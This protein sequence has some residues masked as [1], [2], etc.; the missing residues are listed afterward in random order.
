MSN[1]AD[2]VIEEIESRGQLIAAAH[3]ADKLREFVVKMQA[4]LAILTQVFARARIELERESEK[5]P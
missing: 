3:K 2:K 1:E 5:N 4:E